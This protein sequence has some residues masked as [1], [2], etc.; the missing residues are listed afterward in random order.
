MHNFLGLITYIFIAVGV[1]HLNKNGLTPWHGDLVLM[2]LSVV[3]W[4]FALVG[5]LMFIIL[6]WV[7]IS[8]N[9]IWTAL[10]LHFTIT[11]AGVYE[12][13]TYA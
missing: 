10:F 13:S 9:Y 4:P 11:N 1:S 3:L 6:Y 12:K 5:W 8:S 2:S 7:V